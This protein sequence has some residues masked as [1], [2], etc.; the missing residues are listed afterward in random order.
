ML[1]LLFDFTSTSTTSPSTLLHVLALVVLVHVVQVHANSY[2]EFPADGNLL[3]TAVGLYCESP[4]PNAFTF[5]SG[6][7]DYGPIED[8]RTGLVT[9]M[10]KLFFTR[11]EC[12]PDISISGWDVSSVTN[13]AGMFSGAH[14]FSADLSKWDTSSVKLMGGMFAYARSFSGDISAWDTSSV[15]NMYGMFYLWGRTVQ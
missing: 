10:T 6:G 5:S 13:M 15:T 8:W 4:N 2:A 3:K 11:R 12:N 7:K 9:N 14:L 1:G